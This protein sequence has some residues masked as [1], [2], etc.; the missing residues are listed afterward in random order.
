VVNIFLLVVVVGKAIGS[1]LPDD[2]HDAA[3][4]MVRSIAIAVRATAQL[5]LAL[6]TPSRHPGSASGL[7]VAL[8]GAVVILG[9]NYLVRRRH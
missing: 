7:L 9:I 8:L 4:A 1:V 5:L 3:D 6:P 2:L